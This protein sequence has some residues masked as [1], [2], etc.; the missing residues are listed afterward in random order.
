MKLS[1][2]EKS[3]KRWDEE[4]KEA[5]SKKI[6]PEINAYKKTRANQEQ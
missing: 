5:T 3:N 1:K 4:C 6:M 2:H